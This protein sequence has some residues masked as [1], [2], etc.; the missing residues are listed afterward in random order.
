M[1]RRARLG[2][3]VDSH[4]HHSTA[5]RPNYFRPALEM[6]E[7]RQLLSTVN[8][9]LIADQSFI[10]LTVPN[11]SVPSGTALGDITVKLRDQTGSSSTWTLG[12]T[13]HISGQLATDY[14]DF[15]SIQFSTGVSTLAAQTS[16]NYRPNFAVWNG[17]SYTDSTTAAAD[18]AAKLVG[19]LPLIGDTT[20]GYLAIS[21]L[22]YD[23][24]S[25]PLLFTGANFPANTTSF[26]T[27]GGTVGVD[28]QTV[29]I[30]FLYSGQPV[31]DSLSLLN[32]LSGTNTSAT[33]SVTSLGGLSRQLNLPLN[34]PVTLTVGTSTV[35]GTVTGTIVATATLEPPPSVIPTGGRQLFYNQ[36]TWDGG[37]DSITTS[38]DAAIATDKTAYIA[39]SGSAS[40]S[41]LSSFSR[42]I[43]G[44]MVDLLGGG[45]HT[46]IDAS[47]FI[48]KTG[49]D[50]TPSGWATAPAPIAIT[51]RTGAG[52]SSSDRVEIL[53]GA[54]A[55]KKA[56][57]EV[58]VLNTAHTGLAATDVFY[59]GNMV[60][61]SNLNF[62]TSG[63]DSSNV[64]ANPTGAASISNT[65]DHNR[66]KVVNGT[67]SSL[68]LANVANLTRI[69]LSAG[70]M[71]PVGGGDISGS[72]GGSIEAGPAASAAGDSGIASG[73]SA[74]A[75]AASSPVHVPAWVLDR[76]RK[77]DLN[78]GPVADY[79]Q[80]LH[81]Q[82]TPQA[83][84]ILTKADRIA[85]AL[86]LDDHFLDSLLDDLE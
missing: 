50:N 29:T 23:I 17:S 20:L 63:A 30:P 25:T 54:N 22:T 81:D 65:R 35:N 60:G 84:A 5:E 43:N 36:S 24:A 15:S 31:A 1:H 71:G 69:N 44:V 82:G 56:W 9:D 76:V 32:P 7:D 46:S 45:A 13:S 74:T 64:L 77:L 85:D 58:E 86:H 8:W 73:L 49:N 4:H 66:S 10:T 67:D 55:V 68:A 40:S 61:D 19:A 41:A 59:W 80:Y 78:S 2:R 34:I 47:D 42:G 21:D 16:G 48:F 83:K 26:S 39:G 38:D 33:G 51:V 75:A 6:L 70:S 12:A 11:Q 79:F 72:G 52:V 57:L 18:F 37:V 3:V 62:A 53:W 14:T 28:G 27:T